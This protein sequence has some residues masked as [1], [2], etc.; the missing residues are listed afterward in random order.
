MTPIIVTR[1]ELADLPAITEIYNDAI[2]H[3]TATFDTKVKTPEDQRPWFEAHGER[4]PLL[5]AKDASGRVVGWG[6]LHAWSDRC[7]Y[8]DT[9]E[10]SVYVHPDF[11]GKRIGDQLL[12]A[13]VAAGKAAKLHTI[14]ARISAG[15]EASVR[16]HEAHG[17]VMIGT[18]REVGVKFG[19]LI[20][21]FLMQKML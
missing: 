20:D 4:H 21:V 14:V 13:L 2:L 3:T 8:S 6:S 17:F 9:A 5:V 11:R 7:A 18:M 19:R 10:N 15:N 1:A 16:L 12:G